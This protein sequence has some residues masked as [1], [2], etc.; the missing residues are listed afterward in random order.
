MDLGVTSQSDV[1]ERDSAE[2]A[3]SLSAAAP[4]V[5]ET[6]KSSPVVMSYNEWDPLEEVIVGR[7]EGA[8]IP[9]NHITVTYNLPP[10]V[11]GL[12]RLAAGF[13][14]P[15][16]MKKLAQ[17]ELDGFI[18]LLEGAG[19]KVRRPEIMDFSKKYKTPSWSS[20]GFTIACPRDG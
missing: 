1:L 10:S 20:R 6:A 15:G 4:R 12:Y 8:T 5:P 3:G 7:L 16:W 2:P 17:K 13:K 11:M 9:S 14:Y 19:V 18:A